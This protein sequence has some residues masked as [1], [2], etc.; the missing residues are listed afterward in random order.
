[1]PAWDVG[2]DI[3]TG[4][5]PSIVAQMLVSG[6]ITARGVLPPEQAVPASSFFRALAGRRMRVVRRRKKR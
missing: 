1:M 3:D 4:A 2:V 6:E 5:P